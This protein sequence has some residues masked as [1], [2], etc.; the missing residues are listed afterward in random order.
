MLRADSPKE[1]SLG[2]YNQKQNFSLLTALSGILSSDCVLHSPWA[3]Q[4]RSG[5]KLFC[6]TPLLFQYPIT[7][8][9][10]P[11]SK[12]GQKERPTFN[13]EHPIMNG[14][15][16]SV[17]AG[18]ATSPK[19]GRSKRISNIQHSIS[20]IKGRTLRGEVKPFIF[21]FSSLLHS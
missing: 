20:N 21:S 9:E 1:Y 6:L 16:P 4:D 8:A 15:Y 5:Y 10:Y 7:N 11:T 14:K 3:K 2:K 13:I 19:Q 18:S 17:L 12:E